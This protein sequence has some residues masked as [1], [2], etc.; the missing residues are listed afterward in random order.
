MDAMDTLCCWCRAD[1]AGGYELH[2]CIAFRACLM[3]S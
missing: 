1:S 2:V 3:R